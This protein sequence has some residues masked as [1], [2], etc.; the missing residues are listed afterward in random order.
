MIE[1]P[2]PARSIDPQA[3]A[4]VEAL[5]ASY[6]P[7]RITT[8]FV[9]ESAPI[10]GTFFYDGHNSMLRYMQRAVEAVLPGEGDF[11]DRFRD[12]GWYLDDLVL[13]PVNH[14]DRAGRFAAW[15]SARNSLVARIA[16]YQPLAIVALLSCIK[17]IVAEAAIKAGSTAIVFSVPF[18]GMGNQ[19]KFHAAMQ[20][21][22]PLLPGRS[23]EE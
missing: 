8:L 2:S 6:R 5:R 22:V 13:T 18:P 17:E 1:S 15:N 14:L 4:A 12:H 16:D 7:D 10:N 21:I 11:L 9:G 23:R 20:S 3:V 19:N